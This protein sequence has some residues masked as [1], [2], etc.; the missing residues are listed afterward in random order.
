M[1]LT[2]RVRTIVP[3]AKVTKG[4]ECRRTS[5]T[6]RVH[7][8]KGQMGEVHN[9]MRCRVTR[10]NTGCIGGLQE[11]VNKTFINRKWRRG[12]DAEESSELPKQNI[13]GSEVQ[14]IGRP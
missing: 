14:K 7:V 10:H 11:Y 12:C 5:Q 3:S 9:P 13:E 6:S 1:R 4:D 8:Q 2:R